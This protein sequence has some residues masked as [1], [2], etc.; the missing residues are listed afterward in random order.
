MWLWL[1]CGSVVAAAGFFGAYYWLQRSD[2]Q[3]ALRALRWIEHSLGT[4]GH[5]TGMRWLNHRQFE[6]P[7]KVVYPVFQRAFIQVTL[8]PGFNLFRK[9][10]PDSL[11]F[12]ADLDLRPAFSMTFENLR[13]FARTSKNI[14]AEAPGWTAMN[15][16]PVVLTT[17][18]DWDREA[19]NGIYTILHGERRENM[20]V[21]YRKT[22]PHL[23]AT[24]PLAALSPDEAEPLD[25]LK[26]MR[27]MA[28]G[29]QLK[30]AS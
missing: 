1:V 12:Y 23:C 8:A 28:E 5:V 13:W 27:D 24:L 2:Q 19:T 7:I 10:D 4:A 14:P 11:S 17:R 26:M 22:A 20:T 9:A 18:L 3:R 16:E 29:I 15:C 30:K 25:L 21:S 6:V